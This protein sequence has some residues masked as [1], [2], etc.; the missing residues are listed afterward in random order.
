M[1]LFPNYAVILEKKINYTKQSYLFVFGG[2]G[3]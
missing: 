1:K 3:I 2:F